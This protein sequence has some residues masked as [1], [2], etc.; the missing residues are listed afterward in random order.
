M[1]DQVLYRV[2]EFAALASVTVR[3]LRYYDR[4]GLLKPYQY[5]EAK[6]RRYRQEDL[7][8]LQQ[9]LTLKYI[10]FSLEEIRSLLNS[11]NYDVMHS[12]QIQREAL[13]GRVAQ[14]QKASRALEQ[15]LRFLA[16]AKPKDLDWSLVAEVIRSINEAE[17]WQWVHRYYTPE[18]RKWLE[19]RAKSY[20]PQQILRDKKRW[21]NCP[22]SRDPLTWN[23]DSL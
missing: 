13:D 11:P 22:K 23:Y 18:Q 7:L 20:T 14:L 1:K 10:G 9:I 16:S 8:R 3:T 19:E 5:T 2:K 15:T 4:T 12:L 21:E 17:K 6:H